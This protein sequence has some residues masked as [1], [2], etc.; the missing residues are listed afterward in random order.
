MAILATK[1]VLTLDY[2]KPASKIEVGDYV[3]DQ[4]GNPVKVTLVQH[5]YANDCYE[6]EFNDQLTMA[7][8]KNL[9]FYVE[10]PK[11]RQR[12]VDYKMVQPFKRPLKS[13]SVAQLA[14]M[15]LKNKRNRGTLSVQS[16]KPL[17]FPHQDLPTPPFVFGYWIANRVKGTAMS[18]IPGH[19]DYVAQKFKDFGY[20]IQNRWRVFYVTPTIESQFMPN[21]PHR[22]PLNYLLASVEQR[23]EL[24]SGI[25]H[26]KSRQYVKKYDHFKI[27]FKNP[28][29]LYQIQHLVESL[30]MKTKMYHCEI[31]NRYTLTFKSKLK[32]MEIQ[33]SPPLK[34]HLARRFITKINKIQPQMCVHIETDGEDG[35]FAV[36]EGFIPCH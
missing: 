10:D 11:H 9:K 7:G 23:I 31:R 34:V 8:D 12:I 19:E 33:N 3:F 5:Y 26:A 4:Q 28:H 36:D 2:W 15:P 14:D 17:K 22:I 30:G 29:L 24:L 18:R 16:T 21:V 35:S 6:V 27:S 13:L 1:K 25:L 32:L 20:K